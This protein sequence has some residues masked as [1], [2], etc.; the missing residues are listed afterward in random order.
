MAQHCGR[1]TFR[2]ELRG[3]ISYNSC[4]RGELKLNTKQSEKSLS[5]FLVSSIFCK[6]RENSSLARSIPV[7]D[8]SQTPVHTCVREPRPTLYAEKR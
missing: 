2:I 8:F 6:L 5:I 3:S 1:S 7:G 4:V